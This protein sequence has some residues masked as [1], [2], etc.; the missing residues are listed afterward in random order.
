MECSSCC[1]EVN[2]LVTGQQQGRTRWLWTSSILDL[3][4]SNNLGHRLVASLS[5][6]VIFF[7]DE[8]VSIRLCFCRAR[9]VKE[10]YHFDRMFAIFGPE[11]ADKFVLIKGE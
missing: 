9:S 2:K 11:M 5:I 3:L 8:V 6:F 7:F 4:S 10:L 1:G